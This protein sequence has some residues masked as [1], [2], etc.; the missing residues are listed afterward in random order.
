M[1]T[2]VR[3]VRLRPLT[4]LVLLGALLGLG[5]G[6][7][8]PAVPAVAADQGRNCGPRPVEGGDG[9]IHYEW[10]C[11]GIGGP[12]H[13]GP[14]TGGGPAADTC[15]LGKMNSIPG[16]SPFY[17][18]GK[19][20]C[21]I[22]SAPFDPSTWSPPPP[23]APPGQSYVIE[24]CWPCGGC[25]GPP[26]PRLRAGG[27]PQPRPLTQQA[28]D[29]FGQLNPP[30]VTG[31]GHNPPG[32]LTAQFPTW[33]WLA[34]PDAEFRHVKPGSSA[35]GLRAYADP[36]DVTVDFGD[37]TARACP[38]GG[39]PWSAG[40][41]G[42]CTHTY[43]QASAGYHVVL[44]RHWT[45]HYEVNGRRIDIPGAAVDLPDPTP[46]GLDVMVIERQSVV[47]GPA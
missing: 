23:P 25:Y 44:T 18:V 37:G 27:A 16:Y 17:C 30:P 39:V 32:R 34:H 12:T 8:V 19:A 38:A 35:E 22:R 1:L 21:A 5:L 33:Y 3:S 6:E 15:G 11:D 9:G 28:T 40:A 10:R 47:T 29:A 36:V 20:P 7:V 31:V 43:R 14:G 41:T 26:V 2:T 4:T 13:H 45:V 46:F 24:D 42:G